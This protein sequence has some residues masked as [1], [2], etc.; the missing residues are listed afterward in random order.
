MRRS[1]NIGFVSSCVN[2]F[3]EQIDQLNFSS[4]SDTNMSLNAAMQEIAELQSKLNQLQIFVQQQLQNIPAEN[5]SPSVSRIQEENLI[6]FPNMLHL[7]NE[8]IPVSSAT[9]FPIQSIPVVVSQ[10]I[11]VVGNKFIPDT[12]QSIPVTDSSSS[13]SSQSIPT[14]SK[15]FPVV[16]ET[17]QANIPGNNQCNRVLNHYFAKRSF[18]RSCLYHNCRTNITMLDWPV[19]KCLWWGEDVPPW[20]QLCRCLLY[21][22]DRP[23]EK[24]RDWKLW[25][26]NS[27]ERNI[28][29]W[30]F[31]I[32]KIF[33]TGKVH[34]IKNEPI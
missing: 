23:P 17:I 6:T 18:F 30:N 25:E 12:N 19:A 14:A 3:E 10:F 4:I 28:W 22:F 16:E 2:N 13:I 24:A 8:T 34:K 21:W 26:R 27:F 33:T 31:W 5:L 9:F 11:P 1:S 32:L 15:S 7:Q 29:D 20:K